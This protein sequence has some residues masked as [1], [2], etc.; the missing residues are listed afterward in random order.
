MGKLPTVAKRQ[1]RWGEREAREALAEL[2]A[3]GES[4]ERFARRRRV[5]DQRIY[6]WK[7][8]IADAAAP[9]FVGV[10]LPS[11]RVDQIEIAADG[12]T[13]RVREDMA[14]ERL[15]GIVDV[16]ARLGRGC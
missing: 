6:Y 14:P 2:A 9:A 12:V 5:S 8:R 7:K 3:S 15:A 13:I 4:V 16:L 11:P 1:G 10:S